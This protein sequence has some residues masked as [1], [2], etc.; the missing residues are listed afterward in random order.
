MN[1]SK[2]GIPRV[3]LNCLQGKKKLHILYTFE[4]K[5]EALSYGRALTTYSDATLV[6]PHRTLGKI[7]AWKGP[8]EKIPTGMT[9][10]S[11]GS[12]TAIRISDFQIHP[13][14]RMFITLC[15]LQRAEY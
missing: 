15:L 14:E 6:L 5:K 12:I 3:S 9:E 13:L 2:L 4:S 1:T 7:K 10:N 8:I 11:C